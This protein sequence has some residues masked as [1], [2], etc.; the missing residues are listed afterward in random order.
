MEVQFTA[1]QEAQ[2][3]QL[4]R[5]VG[6]SNAVE[7]LKDTALRF[8]TRTRV[9]ARRYW[10]AKLMPT[11]ANS[12]KKKKWTK[13]CCALDAQDAS[14]EGAANEPLVRTGIVRQLRGFPE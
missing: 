4:A 14:L 13:R 10:K 5:H 8:W 9:F 11:G 7:L 3:A 2:L 1:E 6:K 12:L